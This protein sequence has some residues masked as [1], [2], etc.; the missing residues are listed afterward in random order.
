[1]SPSTSDAGGE[2]G[3]VGGTT[4]AA[5]AARESTR[6]SQHDVLAGLHRGRSSAYKVHHARAAAAAER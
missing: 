6:Q 4:E 2:D 5:A 3:G 1:M